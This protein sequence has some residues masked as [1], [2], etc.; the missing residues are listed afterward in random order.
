M[1]FSNGKG[2]ARL[3]FNDTTVGKCNGDNSIA[4]SALL[5]YPAQP[6]IAQSSQA[7]CS[8]VAPPPSDM[9]LAL[10]AWRPWGE[11]PSCSDFCRNSQLD[12]VS[13]HRRPL[14][15]FYRLQSLPQR[16][17]SAKFG[18]KWEN[19]RQKLTSQHNSQNSTHKMPPGRTITAGQR[20]QGARRRSLCSLFL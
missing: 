4:P 12:I 19:S 1:A 17:G 7:E 5:Q 15:S 18:S 20:T 8:M 14:P 13:L 10:F 16:V 3:L 2:K 9:P 6:W 11:H